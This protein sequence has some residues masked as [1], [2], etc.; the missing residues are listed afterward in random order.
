M[1]DVAPTQ[2]DAAQDAILG[3]GTTY[4]LSLHTADPGQTGASEGTDGRQAITF[5]ASSNGT[6]ASN[7]AQSWASAKGGQ[8]YTDFGIWTAATGGNYLRGGPLNGSYTPTAGQPI[9]FASGAVTLTA[10]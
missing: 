3:T 7:D 9:D 5:A 6:Q 2:L 10:S 8:T 4:F 1:S